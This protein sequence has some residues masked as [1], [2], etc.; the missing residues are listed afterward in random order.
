MEY[1]IGKKIKQLRTDKG[2][3][4]EELAE[5]INSRFGSSINKGMISKWENCLGDPR[6]E[7]VRHLAIFFDKSLDFLLDI[8]QNDPLTIAAHHDD[9]EWTEEELEEIEQFKEFLRMK[10]KNN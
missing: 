6:L 4:Q 1:H 8:E 9:E 5:K 3:S 2:L 7:T 10:K